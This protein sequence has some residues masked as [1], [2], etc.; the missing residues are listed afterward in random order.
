MRLSRFARRV[1]CRCFG[2]PGTIRDKEGIMRSNSVTT[3]KE[4]VDKGRERV[5]GALDRA[6]GVIRR[7]SHQAS[8]VIDKG[9]KRVG[10]TL[11]DSAVLVDPHHHRGMRGYASTHP[12]RFLLAFLL[13]AGVLAFFFIRARAMSED[14]DFDF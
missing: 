13:L 11:Q 6:G 8:K 7:R 10:G 14:E 5:A 12:R 1:L 9:G 2:F 4:R 3:A